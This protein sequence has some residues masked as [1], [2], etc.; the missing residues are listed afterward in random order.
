[1]IIRSVYHLERPGESAGGDRAAFIK[2]VTGGEI[3]A[4][5]IDSNPKSGS[6]GKDGSRVLNVLIRSDPKRKKFRQH[7]LFHAEAQDLALQSRHQRLVGRDVH[8][9]RNGHRR[10]GIHRHTA[11]Y[12]RGQLVLEA[13][14]SVEARLIDV[15]AHHAESQP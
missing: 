15:F 10:P 2:I 11:S 8:V 6:R 7:R 12:L 1:M 3:E 13:T 14:W 5:G 4:E 9:R